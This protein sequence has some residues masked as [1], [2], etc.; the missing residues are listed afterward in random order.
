MN[1]V[2]ALDYPSISVCPEYSFKEYIDEQ[3]L[4]NLSL[5][6]KEMLIKSKLWTRNETFYFVNQHTS[7]KNGYSCMTNRESID[8]GRPCQ[9]PFKHKRLHELTWNCSDVD[10]DEPW[11]LTR[12]RNDS[13]GYAL[14]DRSSKDWGYCRKTVCKFF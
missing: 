12:L 5:H 10:S 14:V 4:G 9:F 8:P 3:I 6:E 1:T 7:L 11:C 13:Y 2:D